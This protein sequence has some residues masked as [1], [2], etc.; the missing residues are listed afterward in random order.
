MC[1]SNG[2]ECGQ[3]SNMIMQT[4]HMLANASTCHNMLQHT[5][6]S[7]HL[8]GPGP[9]AFLSVFLSTGLLSWSVQSVCPFQ[10]FK[11]L[12]ASLSLEGPTPLCR[13]P[14]SNG[15]GLG[16]RTC[17]HTQKPPLPTAKTPARGPKNHCRRG[18]SAVLGGIVPQLCTTLSR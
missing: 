9:A 11:S 15:L 17:T 8:V 18:P 5:A 2:H 10:T 7:Y 1:S 6:K 14:Q 4:W 13:Y 16:S 12:L 3:R